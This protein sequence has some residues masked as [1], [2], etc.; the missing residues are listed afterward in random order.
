MKFGTSKIIWIIVTVAILIVT[1]YVRLRVS[2][3]KKNAEF[4]IGEVLGIR[5]G[6][7]GSLYVFYRFVVEGTE[8]NGR[9]N[10]SFCEK[11]NNQCC[12]KGSKVRVRY[13]KKDPS[14]NDLIPN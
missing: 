2:S 5:E 11:C 12:I 8:Y 9:V 10:T 13:D 1:I 7:K 4:A 3:R 14:N 6:A